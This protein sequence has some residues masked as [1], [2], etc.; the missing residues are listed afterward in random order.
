MKDL[1]FLSK[2]IKI[3]ID[4]LG[5]DNFLLAQI[6]LHCDLSFHDVT[7]TFIISSTIE[8][9]LAIKRFDAPLFKPCVKQ[10]NI[11]A[12]VIFVLFGNNTYCL[13]TRF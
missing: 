6:L 12:V 5:K 13:K 9:N 1:T 7:N 4:I 8:Y 3:N 11:K 10:M 2:I